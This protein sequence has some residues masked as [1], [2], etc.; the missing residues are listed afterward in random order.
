MGKTNFNKLKVSP[1]PKSQLRLKIISPSI[2]RSQP[3]QTLSIGGSPIKFKQSTTLPRMCYQPGLKFKPHWK[4]NLLNNNRDP[5][6][7]RLLAILSFISNWFSRVRWSSMSLWNQYRFTCE[8][9]RPLLELLIFQRDLPS[10]ND[11]KTNKPD[12][13]LYY[14][15][16]GKIYNT[17]CIN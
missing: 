15:N 12:Q 5:F 1:T 8:K 3:D 4:G 2:N 7:I 16:N 13:A 10:L 17:L 6:P 9:S 14:S 11:S